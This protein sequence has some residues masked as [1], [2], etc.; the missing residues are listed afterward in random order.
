MSRTVR[1]VVVALVALTLGWLMP[2]TLPAHATGTFTVYERETYL[3]VDFSAAGAVR[4][5]I[6]NNSAWESLLESGGMPSETDYKAVVS[7]RTAGQAG[8]VILDHEKIYLKGVTRAV[9]EHRRDQWIQLLTWTHDVVPNHTV[10][11]YNFLHEVDPANL[12]LAAE[13]AA[14][15]DAFFPSMYSWIGNGNNCSDQTGWTTRLTAIMSRAASIDP[16]KPV[17]P[18]VWP[19]F[20]PSCTGGGSFLTGPQWRY[21]LDTIQAQGAAGLVIYSEA[22]IN[23]AGDWS[24]ETLDFMAGL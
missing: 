11:I 5:V 2:A 14:Y 12:D 21:Q 18:F 13:V 17:I 6:V 1:T 4:A 10:G 20:Y 8:P 23:A 19:Q 22:K 7:S 24:D 16:A 9:A 3:D 15:A